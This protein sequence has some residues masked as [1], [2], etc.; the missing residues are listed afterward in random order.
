[1][2]FDFRSSQLWKKTLALTNNEY[3]SCIDQLRVS[4]ESIHKNIAYLLCLIQQEFP[5]Y[6]MHDIS[7][8]DALWDM[9]DIILKD[10]KITLNPIEGYV[11]GCSFLFHDLGMSPA[12]YGNRESLENTDI[13]KDTYALLRKKGVSETNATKTS[14]EETIRRSHAENAKK[15]PLKNF[16]DSSKK[17]FYLI[18]DS[19]LRVNLGEII[20]KIASSHGIS[21]ETLDEEFS[22]GNIRVNGFPT[23][24][25]IDPIKLACILRIADAIHITSDRTPFI[26]WVTKQFNEESRCHWTFQSKINKPIVDNGRLIF[27]SSSAFSKSERDS[28]WLCYDTLKMIN[29]ELLDVDALLS[30]H[31]IA[32]LGAWC[33]KNIDS[34]KSIAKLID[35]DGWTPVDS[36][37]KVT[38]VSGLIRSLGGEALYGNNDFA[39]LRELVQNASDAI[40]ARRKLDGYDNS[41]GDIHIRIKEELEGTIIEVEDNGIGMSENVLVG[42]F[43]DFGTSFWHSSLMHKELPGLESLDFESTGHFG[44]GFFSVFMWGDE[45]FV[46]TCKYNENRAKTQVL[47][48]HSGAES[49]PL[50]R[51]A[52]QSEQLKNGGTKIR[53]FLKRRW[54]QKNS[55]DSDESL[56]SSLC[57]LF[58]CMDCNI[59]LST[60]KHNSRKIISANDWI[61]M[62]P[63]EFLKRVYGTHR[64]LDFDVD[65]EYLKKISNRVRLIYDENGHI[66]GRGTIGP[67]V[68]GLLCVGGINAASTSYFTGVLSAKCNVANRYMAYPIISE[69]ALKKWLTEQ[70]DLL[71]GD[72]VW[73][74][75]KSWDLSIGALLYSTDVDTEN[76]PIAYY[77]DKPVNYEQV[78]QII[79]ETNCDKYTVFEKITPREIRKRRIFYAKNVFLTKAGIPFISANFKG[80]IRNSPLGFSVFPSIN[81]RCSLRHII[82][83]ACAEVWNKKVE[84]IEIQETVENKLYET[85]GIYEGTPI[86]EE[87]SLIITKSK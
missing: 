34:P 42:P 33:V 8:A 52:E 56:E 83:D 65:D 1:M 19:S 22:K 62:D 36:Q 54:P 46:S 26:I 74:E 69:K 53:V 60:E 49:R 29:Q 45:V 28:W 4:F 44:I 2:Q 16:T 41:W 31:D 57:R 77:Q 79:K 15:L 86:E 27:N 87:C 68:K 17:S 3:N 32:S 18:E 11:L 14:N 13:W 51:T 70:R 82:A 61:R 39:P 73:E 50:L 85:I 5:E 38:N 37:M 64:D 9:A 7:H 75:E 78:K 67:N 84:D 63:F 12:V 30:R 23:E 80:I 72:P 6:T 21:I 81:D 76:I 55:W 43:L 24:W 40:R 66:V 20:G 10:S 71:E 35:V 58:C 48:F 25:E 47:E 59:F